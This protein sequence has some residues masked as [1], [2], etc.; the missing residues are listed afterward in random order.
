MNADTYTED[1]VSVTRYPLSMTGRK[2]RRALGLTGR[3]YAEKSFRVCAK[4][5]GI[6]R[7]KRL[8]F[9]RKMAAKKLE[10][11]TFA[12]MW[13]KRGQFNSHNSHKLH[14]LH[15]L[16][17]FP[18]AELMFCYCCI[19]N[20]ADIRHH[21]IPLSQGGRNKRNNIVPLCNTCHCK[22]H[23]H[24]HRKNKKEVK[25]EAV[26][27]RHSVHPKINGPVVWNPEDN[28]SSVVAMSA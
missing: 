27:S 18:M 16:H 3:V 8:A 4:F 19:K 17:S 13:A 10:F 9:L 24:M 5:K 2:L 14:K 26:A 25:R 15:K 12:E 20:K 21:V 22:V 1:G 23:P 28:K 11:V 6:K 7:D